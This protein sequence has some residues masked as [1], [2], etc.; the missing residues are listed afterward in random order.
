[1]RIGDGIVKCAGA[2][3]QRVSQIGGAAVEYDPWAAQLSSLVSGYVQASRVE[4]EAVAI[5]GRPCW[6]W[7][8]SAYMQMLLGET[9]IGRCRIAG[10]LD[11]SAYKQTKT[12]GGRRI[13]PPD[14]LA[15]AERGAAV[16]FSGVPNG[17]E[18]NGFLDSLGFSGKRIVV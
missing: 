15:N 2:V 3:F 6:V 17:R 14:M 7:G 5:E 4:A 12:I 11:K 10:L 1:M 13:L 9:A 18:M 16:I 8:I